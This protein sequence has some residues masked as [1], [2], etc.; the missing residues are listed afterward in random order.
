MTVSTDP[1][2]PVSPQYILSAPPGGKKPNEMTEDEIRAWADSI[3]DFMLAQRPMVEEAGRYLR[4]RRQR[5]QR[6]L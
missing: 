5:A 2:P 3:F 6:H 4:E 1:E